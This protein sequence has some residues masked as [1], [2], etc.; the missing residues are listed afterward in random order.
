M[1][2]NNGNGTGKSCKGSTIANGQTI[3]YNSGQITITFP[4]TYTSSAGFIN[5]PI[6]GLDWAIPQS[7]SEHVPQAKV[8]IGNA[9]GYECKCCNDF[10]PMAELN[11]PDK[12]FKCYSC[13]KGL[14]IL[15]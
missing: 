14:A 2:S 1:P 7:E 12:T 13:R 3:S 15:F 6:T 11:M 4:T 10:Y 8:K 9:E 5:M